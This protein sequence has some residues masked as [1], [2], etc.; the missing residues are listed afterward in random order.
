MFFLACVCNNYDV[1]KIK[2]NFGKIKKTN[3]S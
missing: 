2:L 3:K 1:K